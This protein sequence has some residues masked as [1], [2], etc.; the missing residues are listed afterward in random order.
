MGLSIWGELA[1]LP[2]A[3][4]VLSLFV[5]MVTL[6]ILYWRRMID[7]ALTA[8]FR[9]AERIS[10]GYLPEEWAR[11]I[12]RQLT[13]SR[14]PLLSR[15]KLSGTALALKKIDKLRRFFENS[16]FFE[17]EA[18]KNVLLDQLNL[19]RQCWERMSWEE[20]CK[21]TQ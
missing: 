16:P 18:A 17:D 6:L 13:Y 9:A 20:L 10:E 4:L 21:I 5:I 11:Q 8:H 3:L 19:T 2:L 7:G 12:N 1:L 15:R 14:L